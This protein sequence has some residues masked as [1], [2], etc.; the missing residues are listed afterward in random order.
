M[1][2]KG[3]AN[4][5]VKND[6]RQDGSCTASWTPIICA[7]IGGAHETNVIIKRFAERAN[8]ITGSGDH[9][10]VII[11]GGQWERAS[12]TASPRLIVKQH[13]E[14]IW[15]FVIASQCC[16]RRDDFPQHPTEDLFSRYSRHSLNRLLFHP[17]QSRF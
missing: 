8:H 13:R 7:L 6:V 1:K 3:F 17:S 5:P 2:N 4:H 12:P 11:D 9:H 14:N 16:C 10:H 15:V